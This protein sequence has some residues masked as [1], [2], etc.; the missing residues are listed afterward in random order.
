[1]GMWVWFALLLFAERD[2]RV[3]EEVVVVLVCGE[4]VLG[5][6]NVKVV[7]EVLL[8]IEMLVLWEY[9]LN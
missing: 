8:K 7:I 1:M 6:K 4:W 5:E 3:M 9:K 2:A